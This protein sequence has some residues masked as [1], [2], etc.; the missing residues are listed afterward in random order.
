VFESPLPEDLR[1]VLG[2]LAAE[3]ARPPRAPD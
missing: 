3:D 1:A 2:A